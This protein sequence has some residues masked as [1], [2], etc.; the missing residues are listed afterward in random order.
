MPPTLDQALGRLEGSM[1]AVHQRLDR[2]E[3]KLDGLTIRTYLTAGA[4]GVIVSLVANIV[5]P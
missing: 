1:R 5:A 3:N 2:I 4:V